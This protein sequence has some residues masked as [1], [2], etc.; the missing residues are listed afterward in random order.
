MSDV[1][2]AAGEWNY[3][4]LVLAL[5]VAFVLDAMLL[6]DLSNIGMAKAQVALIFL[7][8]VVVRIAVARIRREKGKGWVFYLILLYSSPLWIEAAGW[9]AFGRY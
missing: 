9:L 7:A 4:Q 5:I 6:P 2:K 1:K 8:L 3:V